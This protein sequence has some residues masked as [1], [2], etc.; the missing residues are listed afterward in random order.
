MTR[1]P[2]GPVF[3]LFFLGLLP[4]ACSSDDAFNKL[5]AATSDGTAAEALPP[6]GDTPPAADVAPGGGP[7]DAPP[8]DAAVDL[9]ADASAPDAPAPDAALPDAA[10]SD[11]LLPD[12]ARDTGPEAVAMCGPIRCD[13]TFKGKRLWGK[14]KFVGALDF[15]DITVKVVTSNLADLYVERLSFPQIPT[16]CG[17]WLEEQDF[18]DFKVRIADFAE[19][20]DFEIQYDNFRPGLPTLR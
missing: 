5:D 13:C 1:S 2:C 6:S 11:A 7:A 4:A 19:L 14:V 9:P 3:A 8:P 10:P 15:P 12:A 17:Q 16:R 18:P 20:A